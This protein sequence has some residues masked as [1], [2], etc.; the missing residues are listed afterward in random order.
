MNNQL[1]TSR[2]S[3]TSLKVFVFAFAFTI[4]IN[5]LQFVPQLF[6]F[7]DGIL[8]Y[9]GVKKIIFN[10]C[11]LIIGYQLIKITASLKSGLI[12]LIAETSLKRL[13]K[14]W[15]ALIALLCIKVLW[16]VFMI[17]YL[18]KN[19]IN[20]SL[21]NKLDFSK[22]IGIAP[23]S[24]LLIA[25]FIVWILIYVLNYALKLKKEQDLTI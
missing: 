4:L 18:R 14:V 7:S 21:L 11:Y 25:V 6:K 1:N 22:N 3:N 12:D 16:Q 13:N 8:F 19:Y 10:V 15:M 17:L 20:Q 2:I 9:D 5:V 24:D 23:H